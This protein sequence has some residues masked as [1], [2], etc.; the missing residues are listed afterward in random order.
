[1]PVAVGIAQDQQQSLTEGEAFKLG[2]DAYIYG[3]PLVVMDSVRRVNTN[4]ARPIWKKRPLA[5]PA[6]NAISN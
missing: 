3:Y 4:V 5:A 2:V 6:S 1:M